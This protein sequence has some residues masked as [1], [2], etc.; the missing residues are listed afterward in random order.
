MSKLPDFNEFT[1]SLTDD[2]LLYIRELPEIPETIEGFENI[3]KVIIDISEKR[4]VNLLH[5]YHE[6]L[7]DHLNA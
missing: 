6:W 7:Q 1:E 5:V 2:D 3:A 4:C